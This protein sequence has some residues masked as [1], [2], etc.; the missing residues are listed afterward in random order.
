MPVSSTGRAA[1]GAGAIG[2]REEGAE[3]FEFVEFLGVGWGVEDA[4]EGEKAKAKGVKWTHKPRGY[5][6]SKIQYFVWMGW[7][8]GWNGGRGG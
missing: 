6:A 3:L 5:K 4:G 2:G 7:G 1:G 8:F